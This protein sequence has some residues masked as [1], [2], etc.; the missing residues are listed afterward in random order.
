MIHFATERLIDSVWTISYRIVD[1]VKSEIE[2]LSY[3][4]ENPIGY[5]QEKTLD[6]LNIIEGEGRIVTSI[7]VEPYEP[8]KYWASNYG[9]IYNVVNPKYIFS[10]SK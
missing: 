3:D 4:R 5:E 1:E 7:I 2:I 10:Y 9:K 6:R 8:F